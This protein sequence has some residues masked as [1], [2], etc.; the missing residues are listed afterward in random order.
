MLKAEM[1]STYDFS[2]DK[3]DRMLSSGKRK[4]AR[5]IMNKLDD[6]EVTLN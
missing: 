3:I 5:D 1:I 2:F 4:P 6:L